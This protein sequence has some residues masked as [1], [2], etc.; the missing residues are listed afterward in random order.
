MEF[1]IIKNKSHHLN[2]SIFLM[3]LIVLI[4]QVLLKKREKLSQSIKILSLLKLSNNHK[5]FILN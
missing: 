1:H 4:L 5:I 2:N 3:I